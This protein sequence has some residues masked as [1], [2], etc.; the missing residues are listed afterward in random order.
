VKKVLK[1]L[2]EEEQKTLIE[3]A[4][5]TEIKTSQI[6][7]VLFKNGYSVPLRTIRHFRQGLRYE[8]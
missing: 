2:T 5:D 4:K 1:Q 7:E 8:N 3:I 6:A